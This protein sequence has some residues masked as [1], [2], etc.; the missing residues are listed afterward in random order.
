MRDEIERGPGTYSIGERVQRA[1]D[2][3]IEHVYWLRASQVV[4]RVRPVVSPSD[5]PPL[6]LLH[7]SQRNTYEYHSLPPWPLPMPSLAAGPEALRVVLPDEED[8]V[9]P[10]AGPSSWPEPRSPGDVECGEADLPDP[11]A[12]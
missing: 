11:K 8:T 6:P 9:A 2:F 1:A 12:N 3:K 10:V 7:A 5:W 4:A